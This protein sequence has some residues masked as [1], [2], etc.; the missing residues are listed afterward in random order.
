MPAPLPIQPPRP[1]R[2]GLASVSGELNMPVSEWRTGVQYTPQC[3][4]VGFVW[5][6]DSINQS[7]PDDVK[8]LTELGEASDWYPG[9][10]GSRVQCTVAGKQTL[11]GDV[12]RQVAE[13]SLERV[14]YSL[15]AQ[16]LY[17]GEVGR[18]TPNH[19]LLADAVVPDGF[20]PAAPSGILQTIQGL[21]D[22]ACECWDQQLVFHVPRPYLPYFLA[23]D[24]VEWDNVDQVY[25]MGDHLVSFD[26]YQNLGPDVFSTGGLTPNPDGSEVWIYATSQPLVGLDS[27]IMVQ[28]TINNPRL[29]LYDVVAEQGAIIIVN[30]CCMVGAK[31]RVCG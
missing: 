12:V 1:L 29:N 18:V 14:R 17:S 7:A 2:G 20:N 6:C 30:P 25:R 15:L 31:A 13:Q 26:C 22:H 11:I 19:S 23:L 16:I 24:I 3:D 8:P 5:G 4:A 9:V 21:L 28:S 27:D 10:I